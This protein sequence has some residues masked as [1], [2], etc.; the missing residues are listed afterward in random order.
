PADSDIDLPGLVVTVTNTNVT[1]GEETI[2]TGTVNVITDAVAD[3]PVVDAQDN[4]G[5]KNTILNVDIQGA[6][7]DLDGSENIVKYEV[8]GVPDGFGFSSGTNLG[9]GVWEFT[10]AQLI[11]L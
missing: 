2:V 10:P 9:G 11:G 6:V 5:A 8:S 3:I 7:T 1:T 4:A